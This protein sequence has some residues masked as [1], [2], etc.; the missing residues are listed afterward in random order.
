M[1]TSLRNPGPR[2][3]TLVEI[4]VVLFIL[5]IVIAM[6]AAI[7][8]GVTAAQKRSLTATR[9]AGVDAALAQ[10]VAQ[11]KRLPCPADGTLATG[12]AN[13]GREFWLAGACTTANQ[14][15]GV[16]PWQTLGLTELEA[17]DGWD[18]RMTYRVHPDLVRVAGMDMSACDPAGGDVVGAAA[19]CA[20]CSSTNLAACTA[21]K[22]FLNGKGLRV[23]SLTALLMD[24]TAD[25]HT[26][27]A[28][29]VI[30]HGESGGGGYMYGAGGLG[31]TSST[32]GDEEKKNYATV[33]YDAAATYYLV[34]NTIADGAGAGHFDDIVSRPSVMG[35]I[36]KAGL[37]PRSH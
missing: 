13:L 12:A 9:M 4:A 7:T 3:F 31:A 23:R 34:D 32:D 35:V 20:A 22:K 16:V 10:F 37:G 27:A 11:Q 24:P 19:A 14:V 17:T 25:P 8:R 36:S 15:N 30:S 33:P 6:A 29:V 2:G 5:A 26:G 28:Y 18:R 21:P 1:R